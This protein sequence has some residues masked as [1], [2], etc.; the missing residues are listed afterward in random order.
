MP[1]FSL[2]Q[3]LSTP[4]PSES[5]GSLQAQSASNGPDARGMMDYDGFCCD[6]SQKTDRSAGIIA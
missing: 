6:F 5:S 3:L 4:I 2:D 1:Q